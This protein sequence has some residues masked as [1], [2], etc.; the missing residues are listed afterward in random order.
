MLGYAYPALLVDPESAEALADA[1][2]RLWTDDSL[3]AGLAQAGRRRVASWTE[4]DFGDRPAA[5]LEEGYARA[6]S[7]AR[8]YTP[9][10]GDV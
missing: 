5:I 9:W 8:P 10:T 2:L 1:M 4:Q 7:W 6:E 3:H